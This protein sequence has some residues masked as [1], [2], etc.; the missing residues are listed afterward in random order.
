MIAIPDDT[1]AGSFETGQALVTDAAAAVR[2]VL[3]NGREAA[4]KCEK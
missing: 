1:G 3:G 2:K 4:I